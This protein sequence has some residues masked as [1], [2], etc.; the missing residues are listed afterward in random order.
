MTF[1]KNTDTVLLFFFFPAVFLMLCLSDIFFWLGSDYAFLIRSWPRSC[2]LLWLWHLEVH[3]VFWSFIGDVNIDYLVKD[4]GVAQFFDS[5]IMII[6][7]PL[8]L[9]GR[10]LWEHANILLFIKNFPYIYHSLLILAR[11]NFYYSDCKLMIFPL[12]HSLCIYQLVLGLPCL[13]CL[14]PSLPPF[15]HL[16]TYLPFLFPSCWYG[17]IISFLKSGS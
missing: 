14:P 11:S 16:P 5:M 13:L 17:L 4:Q 12:Q 2:V 10:Y 3:E 8:Q 15:L 9:I 1:L 7:L 6:F